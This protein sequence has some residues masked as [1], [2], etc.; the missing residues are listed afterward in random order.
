MQDLGSVFQT[1]ATIITM[2]NE[3]LQQCL[4][5]QALAKKKESKRHTERQIE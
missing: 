4:I 3:K 5:S 1:L 2:A